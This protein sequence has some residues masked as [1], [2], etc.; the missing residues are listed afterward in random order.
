MRITIESS[1]SALESVWRQWEDQGSLHVFQ[2]RAIV[3]TWLETAA[4]AQGRTPCLALVELDNAPAMLFPLVLRP[5]Y[6]MMVLEFCGGLLCDYEAPVL[7]PDCPE[8]DARAI[9]N[10]W[11]AI[12][13]QSGAQAAH[14]RQIST[15]IPTVDGIERPNPLTLLAGWC[16]GSSSASR[17]NGTDGAIHLSRIHKKRLAQD[18]RRQ[19]KRL[20][21]LGEVRFTIASTPE[22]AICFTRTMI[23]QKRRRY[24]ETGVFD[25]FSLPGHEEFYLRMAQRWCAPCCSPRAHISAM[26]L[27]DEILATHWGLHWRHSFNYLMPTYEAGS[28]QRFSCGRLLLEWLITQVLD[29]NCTCFDFTVGAEGYKAD[30]CN[31]ELP[32]YGHCQTVGLRGLAYAAML[33][34]KQAMAQT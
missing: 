33:W 8:L 7:A 5:R 14:L 18:S 4:I 21:E 19:L 29:D 23:I 10:I 3:Q 27:N 9:K 34:L 26:L 22:E 2:T 11:N 31:E 12:V 13:R 15:I 1:V 17:T 30:W 16:T 28:W 6:G 25:I 20:H 32:L 24:A